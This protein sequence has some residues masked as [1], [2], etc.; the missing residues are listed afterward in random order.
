VV[1]ARPRYVFG[2]AVE[3]QSRINCYTERLQLG[4][5]LQ[6]AASDL[7]RSYS[8]SR[9]ELRCCA[10]DDRLQLVR[11]E[12]QIVPQEPRPDSSRAVGEP[13]EGWCGVVD[14]QNAG[15]KCTAR[16]LL[17]MQ[18]PKNCHLCTIAQLCRAIS[19]Q[20]RHVSTIG[21][22]PVKHQYLPHMSPNM[23]NFGL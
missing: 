14:I 23:V 6:P 1:V 20:L 22:K 18:D 13:L 4:C 7:D 15:L 11:V 3:P 19:S 21:K 5:N 8:G 2:M 17:E 16:G 9:S 10:K 12:L